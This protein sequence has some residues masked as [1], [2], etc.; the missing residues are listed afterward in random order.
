MTKTNKPSGGNMAAFIYGNPR[1]GSRFVG[2]KKKRK[3][4]GMK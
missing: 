3:T 4:R 2:K 1:G